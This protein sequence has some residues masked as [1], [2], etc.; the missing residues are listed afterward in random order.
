MRGSGR[1]LELPV[2]RPD[3]HFGSAYLG[4]ARQ[5]PRER[6]QGYSTLAP[7][8]ATRVARELRGL[9]C[10]RG[11]VPRALGM[12][13]VTVHRGLYAQSGFFGPTCPVQAEIALRAAG[14]RLLARDGPIATFE[15]D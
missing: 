9:S 4:Y 12:R 13:Y 1:L 5:S 14:W 7:R 6:P 15:R 3:V 10:G 2:F 11:E 8:T